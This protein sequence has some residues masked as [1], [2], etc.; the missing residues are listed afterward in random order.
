[1]S[2]DDSSATRRSHRAS[3]PA[4]AE[5]VVAEVYLPHRL[6]LPRGVASVD[7]E[8]LTTRLGSLTVGQVSYGRS[9]RIHTEV[10][11]HVYVV[12]V[13]RGRAEVRLGA[14]QPQTVEVGGGAAF[15]VGVSGHWSLS[16]DCVVM[17]IM[18]S[19]ETLQA[20]LEHLLGQPLTQPLELARAI[21]LRSPLGRT[22]EPLLRLLVQELRQPTPLTQHPASARR[23]EAVI[24][25]ALLLGHDHNHRELLDRTAAVPQLSAV[26]RAIQLIE[27][28]PTQDW[29]TVRLAREVHLSV[30]AL[31]ARF[32]RDVSMS[33]MDYVRHARLRQVRTALVDATPGSTTV[34]A[35]AQRYGFAHAG[36]FAATYRETFGESPAETLRRPPLDGA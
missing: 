29:S 12:F 28:D 33:P 32:R 19:P 27:A 16:D 34:G 15:P 13:L 8:M 30:R 9:V 17:T 3:T 7:L 20:E 24:L 2:L 1:M 31:Q 22:W 36:R 35:L 25:D 5:N 11:R 26:G 6:D 23:V 18:L 21:D 10:T 4:E 14:G